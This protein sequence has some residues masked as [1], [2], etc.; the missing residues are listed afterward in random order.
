VD[1]HLRSPKY[2]PKIKSDYDQATFLRNGDS[3]TKSISPQSYKPMEAFNKTQV[4]SFNFKLK[5][6][7]RT[8]TDIAIKTANN[9]PGPGKYDLKQIEK[10]YS[11]ISSGLGRGWK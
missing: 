6:K 4:T 9:T 11:L 5:G 1:A 10:G 8:Q 3:A 2:K 7:Q